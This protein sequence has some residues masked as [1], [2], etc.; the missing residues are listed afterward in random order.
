MKKW[1]VCLLML[2]VLLSASVMTGFAE[3]AETEEAAG[4]EIPAEEMLPQPGACG[5]G[6]QWQFSEGVLT[7]SGTGPMYDF[8]EGQE[9]WAAHRAEI[10][11]LRLE[12]GVTTVGANAFRDYDSL[13]RVDL[14]QSL[15]ELGVGAFALCDGLQELSF[16][17]GFRLLGEESLVHCR[18]L[19]TLHFAGGMP[20]FRLN[21]LWDVNATL[22]YPAER[23]WPLEHVQQLTEA[24]QGRIRF[25]DTEGNTPLGEGQP[26]PETKEPVQTQSTETQ[27]TVV[28]TVPPETEAPETL[29][30][31]TE[32]EKAETEPPQTE[33][34]ETKP[35][36]V[37]LPE[38]EQ[39]SGG[40]GEITV[41][42]ALIG[43]M[44]VSGGGIIYLIARLTHNSRKDFT[45]DF[46]EILLEDERD[47]GR[48]KS[49]GRKSGPGSRG[50]RR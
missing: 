18:N 33:Q 35:A 10:T 45:G 4:E 11:E 13:T 39:K 37:E 49:S 7:V 28:Q 31:M 46:S 19:K 27:P 40:F 47:R 41:V 12:G 16:P 20:S 30:V 50:G 24:F 25:E 21:C 36:Y 6:L 38:P 42:A 44:A 23:P 14:G 29:P 26:E 15:T 5:D 8:T 3:E 22:I 1:M 48:K 32:P 9:P 43:L 17:G 2:A 34:P